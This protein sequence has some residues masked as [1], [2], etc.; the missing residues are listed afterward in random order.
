V[1]ASVATPEE[2]WG[3][4]I[5][6]YAL[7]ADLLPPSGSRW[8]QLGPFA[9][10]F[11]GYI[12]KATVPALSAFIDT[13]RERYLTTGELPEGLTMLR[14][15]LFGEQ[16]RDH[17]GG[18]WGGP[19]ESTMQFIHALVERIRVLVLSG[20]GMTPSPHTAAGVADKVMNAFDRFLVGYATWGGHRFHGWTDD[21]DAHNFL[22]TVIW[23]EADCALRFAMELD[24]EWPGA[25]HLEFAIGKATR[26][27]YDPLVE[28]PQRVDVAVSD[29]SSFV[30][31][32]TSQ[33]RYRAHRHE[34]FF[35]VK[36]LL[37][38]WRG[39]AWERDAAKRVQAIPV[40]V[41]KLAHHASLGRCTVAGMLV[42]DDE[43]Y[44]EEHGHDDA[45]PAEVWRLVAGPGALDKRG[46]VRKN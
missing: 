22:G 16:R 40:D 32:A 42:V 26:A 1:T 4:V 25:T 3:R 10:T 7:T 45:W 2:R 6:H 35:E 29:L 38:G 15:A 13:T 41:A 21:S 18:G 11:D 37:K 5:P 43:S 31:D 28:K 9:L 8:D 14:T 44:F 46:L 23:S 24:R 17:F 19:D 20:A 27:D 33:E 36:W 12:V 34:A 39:H 30:E